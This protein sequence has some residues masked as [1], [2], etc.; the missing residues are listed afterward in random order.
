[1]DA[2]QTHYQYRGKGDDILSEHLLS[3]RLEALARRRA[4][5]EAADFLHRY[6]G[7]HANAFALLLSL[8][9]A[10]LGTYHLPCLPD[11][12]D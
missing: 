10:R 2:K 6:T 7:I 3:Q 8:S 4:E 1:L 12:D 5:L 9:R 11:D